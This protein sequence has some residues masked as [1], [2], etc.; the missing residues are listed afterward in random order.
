MVAHEHLHA[1]FV[2]VRETQSKAAVPALGAVP[3]PGQVLH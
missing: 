1:K 3:I 2:Y